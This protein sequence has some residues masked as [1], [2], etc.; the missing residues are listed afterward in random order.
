VTSEPIPYEKP[1][2]VSEFN[3]EYDVIVVGGEPEGVAAAVSAARNGAKT[4]LIESRAELGG[5][6]TYGMLNFL[7]IPQGEDGKSVSKGIYEE[8]HK[9]A[10]A[11]NAFGIKEAKAAFKKLVDGEDN[12][13]LTSE[14]EVMDAIL[15]DMK[16]TGVKLKNKYG[17]FEVTGK[18]L[19]DATQDADFAVMAGAPYFVGGE[20]I[21]IQDKKM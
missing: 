6:F 11:G 21:G 13:T 15:N 12:L 3:E 2:A 18:T 19:I 7:D 17:E 1:D 5:L 16:I 14:T 8:W 9:L 4:L 10:K 20:D